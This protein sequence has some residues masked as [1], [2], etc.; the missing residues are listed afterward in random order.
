M[1]CFVDDKIQPGKRGECKTEGSGGSWKSR[2]IS[3]EEL[4]R[5]SWKMVR[6]ASLLLEVRQSP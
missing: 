3:K 2:G 1:T 5:S 6:L 4:E